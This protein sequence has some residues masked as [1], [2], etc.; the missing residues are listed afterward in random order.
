MVIT[1]TFFVINDSKLIEGVNSFFSQKQNA[2]SSDISKATLF[3][4]QATALENSVSQDEEIM[5][6]VISYELKE[7]FTKIE[8]KY[9][10]KLEEACQ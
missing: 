7:E 3:S 6:V 4:D 5:E 10:E 2:Y 8:S 1:K 9:D